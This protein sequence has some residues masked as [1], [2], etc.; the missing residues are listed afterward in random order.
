M[1]GTEFFMDF[2]YSKQYLKINDL[3]KRDMELIVEEL[4]EVGLIDE[5]YIN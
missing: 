3:A 4:R 5:S 2:E 1:P